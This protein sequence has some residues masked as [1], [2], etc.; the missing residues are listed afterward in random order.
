MDLG[1][2]RFRVSGRGIVFF[3]DVGFSVLGVYKV[4]GFGSVHRFFQILGF[5]AFRVSSPTGPGFLAVTIG[6]L[7]GAPFFIIV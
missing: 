4:Q 5:S 2:I 6:A 7:F 3:S 1:Y